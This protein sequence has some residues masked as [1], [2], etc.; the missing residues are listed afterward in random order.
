MCVQTNEDYPAW[1][2]ATPASE[3]C[4]VANV[5]TPTIESGANLPVMVWIHGGTYSSGSAG[6]AMYDGGRLSKAENV[7]VVSINHRLN[8]F[9]YLYLG[10]MSSAYADS[11]N[12]GLQEIVLFLS[13]PLVIVDLQGAQV[14]ADI[15]KRRF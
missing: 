5:W 15:G 10:G 7:V 3:D 14:S 4:L 2:D 12:L 13:R 1:R 11:A 6:L 9:G 8:I